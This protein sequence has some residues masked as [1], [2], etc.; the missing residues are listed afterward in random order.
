M[1]RASYHVPRL[2]LILP[3]RNGWC[4]V[5]SDITESVIKNRFLCELLA[6]SDCSDDCGS[7]DGFAAILTSNLLTRWQEHAKKG[8]L[9]DTVVDLYAGRAIEG[10]QIEIYLNRLYGRIGCDLAIARPYVINGTRYVLAPATLLTAMRS[11]FA[12]DDW[13]VL[14]HG[15]PTDTNISMDL[16]GRVSWIDFDHSG[17]V[18]VAGEI[19]CLLVSIWAHGAWIAPAYS[20]RKHLN[21]EGS[22]KT[23]CSSHAKGSVVLK[24][25]YVEINVEQ[26]TS[27]GRRRFVEFL[28]NHLVEEFCKENLISDPIN[29][30]R[31][32]ILARLAGVFDP[33]RFSESAVAWHIAAITRLANAQSVADA[34]ADF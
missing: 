30:L 26:K 4:H 19:A 16:A 34:L 23:V 29:W 18:A 24:G 2:L 32:W 31:P 10:G 21:L 17:V 3:T 13:I 9:R 11:A 20:P 33:A 22:W 25:G 1:R 28:L 14:G 6:S 12:Q 8:D 27:T 5:Y 15:D 7:N